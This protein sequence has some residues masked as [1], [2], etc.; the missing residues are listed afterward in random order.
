MGIEGVFPLL[1][2]GEFLLYSIV[3]EMKFV[4]R[5]KLI[6]TSGVNEMK[7]GSPIYR[8]YYFK[9]KKKKILNIGRPTFA[10]VAD[11]RSDVDG[12]GEA[13]AGAHG[14]GVGGRPAHYGARQVARPR[15]ASG[16]GTGGDTLIMLY[17]Q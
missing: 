2:V 15:R 8:V 16:K 13:I 7:L 3:V 6:N 9:K 5:E 17:V 12:R 14:T 4:E 11:V 1:V 10:T